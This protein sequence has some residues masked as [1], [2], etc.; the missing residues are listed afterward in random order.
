MIQIINTPKQ[1]NKYPFI[2]RGKVDKNLWLVLNPQQKICLES[3]NSDVVGGIYANINEKD[4]SITDEI[5]T[6]RNL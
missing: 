5:V 2:A 1:T 6:L 3:H 4:L